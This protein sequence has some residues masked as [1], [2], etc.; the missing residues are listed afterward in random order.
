[1]PYRDMTASASITLVQRWSGLPGWSSKGSSTDGN[2]PPAVRGP[3]EA[4]YSVDT[5]E[6]SGQRRT[7]PA[8]SWIA[9]S[10]L[11]CSDRTE[12]AVEALTLTAAP[13]YTWHDEVSHVDA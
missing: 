3:F 5:I 7:T 1:M 6:P 9:L 13:P 8:V 2:E 4:E 10:V 12:L 11:V